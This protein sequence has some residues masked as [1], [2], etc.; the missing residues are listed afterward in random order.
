M[1]TEM[2]EYVVG[3]CLKLLKLCDFVDYNVRR[4]GGGLAGLNE[5]DVVGLDFKSKTAYLCE[6][7][8]HLD[9]LLYK[10]APTTIERIR[11]K[12]ER[13]RDYAKD[14]L[15]DFPSQ[16]FMF[17]SPVVRESVANELKKISGL[18]LVINKDYTAYVELLQELAK[19]GTHDTGNPT[20]RVLQILGHLR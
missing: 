16:H 12:Y 17:W 10:D 13:L 4:P 9:G 18:E 1:K 14:F 8:T 15:S 7:T 2:G 6:V 3:A 11:K 5:I 19:K 20:F